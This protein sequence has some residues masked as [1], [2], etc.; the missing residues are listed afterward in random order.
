MYLK[1]LDIKGFKSFAEQTE[2]LFQPGLNVVVG[3]NGCGK[4]N[5]VDSIRWVLGE[6]NVRRLRGQKNEDVIFT[7]TDNKRPLSLA[8][9]DI[10]IN[11]EDGSLPVEYT[12]VT[13]SRKVFR[14][15]ESEFYLNKVPVRLKDIHSLFAGTGLGKRGYSII[16]QGELDQVLN[17]RPFERRLI[18]EEASGIIKYRHKMED[19]QERLS[20]TEQDLVRVSDLLQ[21]LTERLDEL[22]RKAEKAARY[23]EMRGEIDNLEKMVLASTIATLAR[24]VSSRRR[25][26]GICREEMAEL[27]AEITSRE[28]ELVRRTTEVEDRKAEVAAYKEEK[29]R[30]GSEINRLAGEYK[31]AE[32]RIKNARERL[33]TVA[34]DRA[35]YQQMLDKLV[36]DLRAGEQ[37]LF[38]EEEQWRAKAEELR[39]LEDKVAGM[40]ESLQHEQELY[41]ETKT[42]LIDKLQEEASLKNELAD[43]E[44]RIRRLS[45]RR[46]R[47]RREVEDRRVAVSRC[48]ES[49]TRLQREL[50]LLADELSGLQREKAGLEKKREDI[51]SKLHEEETLLRGLEAEI[52]KLEHQLASF[53]E[54]DEE[55][56]VYSEGVRSILKAA[57]GSSHLT[58]I[59]GVVGDLLEV[60][61][62]LE[63]AIET[64]LGRGIENL[65][66][67]GEDDARKAIQFLKK[68]ALGR[69]TFLPLDLLR[70]SELEPGVRERVARF[71]GVVGWAWE[72]VTYQPQFAKAVKYLLGRVVVVES[73]KA[74]VN[75]FREKIL[76]VRLVTLEGEVINFSG[77]MTGGKSRARGPELLKRKNWIKEQSVLL[78][79]KQGEYARCGANIDRLKAALK[80]VEDALAD[81]T[82]Q[83]NDLLL[84]QK[85]Q[86]LEVANL[87]RTMA[88]LNEEIRSL[89]EE[90][91]QCYREILGLEEAVASLRA[92]FQIVAGEA[93]RISARMERLREEREESLRQ[94]EVLKERRASLAEYVLAKEK[95]LQKL[96]DNYRQFYQVRESYLGALRGCEEQEIRLQADIERETA[97]RLELASTIEG[98]E[99]ELARLE[100]KLAGLQRLVAERE[101][102]MNKLRTWLAPKKDLFRHREDRLRSMEIATARVETELKNHT[103]AWAERFGPAGIPDDTMVLGEKEKKEIRAR[104]STLHRQVEE[105]GAVD[106]GAENEYREVKNRY[107]FLQEQHRDIIKA[108]D[109]LYR[110][111]DDTRVVLSQQFAVFLQMASDSFNQTFTEIFGGGEAC[112]VMDGD[113]ARLESGVEFMVKLPGKRKQPLDL[114][115]GGERALTCIAF[116]FALLRL[117]PAPFCLL[118]EIDSSLDD[119]NLGRFVSFLRRLAQS[120]QFIVVTHRQGTIE[121]GENIYGV[122]MP[123]EGVSRVLS[124]TLREAEELAG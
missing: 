14:S 35:K 9:V 79:Q 75:V 39:S 121:S 16:G 52:I 23:R 112:L 116:I 99:Q 71:P 89:E 32:E 72:L 43:E 26:T 53:R 94:Y 124:V 103:T 92:R 86:A 76:P 13:V 120:I 81:D 42:E 45:E 106:P 63:T 77:A 69:A 4:S 25:E 57:R 15:G 82:V 30:V 3:P 61:P 70:V 36:E 50:A 117:K 2:I 119:I 33:E 12:E 38:G 11:N 21:V 67:K 109:S 73:L 24:E 91:S 8:Q 49:L 74:G 66:V 115:S 59:L 10:V 46:E 98:R 104:I 110:L 85:M 111:L 48:D 105:L 51:T 68:R 83:E 80:E 102:E 47:C 19:A 93:Q 56:T 54:M 37:S 107:D 44:E 90:D 7:G 64:A 27:E 62:G 40:D 18:L 31:L 95:E 6:S 5:I 88:K 65:V 101:D 100:D 84:R 22:G 118:D 1:R 97:R 113:A 58:G 87:E 34:R 28:Q 55:Y 123:E 114:L 78:K 41:E 17:A 96:R 29:Y 20:L 108:R 60:P 122:T